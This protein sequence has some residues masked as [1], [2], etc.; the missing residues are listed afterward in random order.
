MRTS[1]IG[2]LAVLFIGLTALT[3]S[4][5]KY[6]PIK[7][8]LNQKPQDNGPVDDLCPPSPEGVG[9]FDLRLSFET[10]Q[11]DTENPLPR[12]E[13]GFANEF[14]GSSSNVGFDFV[15]DKVLPYPVTRTNE[16]YQGSAVRMLSR[17]GFRMQNMGSHIIP[18]S[19]FSGKVDAY[20]L[21]SAPLESTLFGRSIKQRPLKLSGYY[22]YKAGPKLIKGDSDQA[23]P[24][25]GVDECSIAAVFFE[26]GKGVEFLNGT[27]LYTHPHVISIA[28][29][30]AGNSEGWKRFELDFVPIPGKTV[31]LK[32]KRYK[33]AFA[34]A[35]SARGDE[36]I[37]AIDSEL[38]LDELELKLST[39]ND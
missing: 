9:E 1:K 19:I 33:I 5:Y 24:M 31:D 23:I 2:I 22:S 28:R 27:N 39:S 35:S 16:G 30:R 8:K 6:D 38:L 14:W 26:A 10:W 15:I 29:M 3:Q 37:G 32:N 21:L 4:C 18:A 13:G 36:Y 7:D 11:N 12:G 25:E 34:F 20:K 17:P